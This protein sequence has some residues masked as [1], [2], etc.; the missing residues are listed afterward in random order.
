MKFSWFKQKK[1]SQ[2]LLMEQ[3][4]EVLHR[5]DER[6]KKLESCVRPGVRHMV[7]RPHMVT[8]H[9]ND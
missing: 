8:G 9:W 2:E 6:L 1:S 7:D 5:I 4:L 3:N